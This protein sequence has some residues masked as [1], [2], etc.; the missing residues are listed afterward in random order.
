MHIRIVKLLGEEVTIYDIIASLFV[1]TGLYLSGNFKLN[2]S[3]KSSLEK[4]LE[5]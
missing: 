3:P 2:K 1:F 5:L 4:K